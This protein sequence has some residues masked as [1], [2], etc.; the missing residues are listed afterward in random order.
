ME[1]VKNSLDNLQI[2][3]DITI[4]YG[5]RKITIF[6]VTICFEHLRHYFYIDF[7]DV[8]CIENGK[9]ISLTGNESE[10]IFTLIEE[11]A[12]TLIEEFSKVYLK[13]NFVY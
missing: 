3:N 11:K 12:K 7:E 6:G 2:K 4:Q 8:E 1:M 13:T 5:D 10:E 9:V